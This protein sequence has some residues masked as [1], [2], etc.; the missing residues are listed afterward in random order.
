MC[1]EYKI[2]RKV[3]EGF[4]ESKDKFSY[5]DVSNEVL[6][7]GGVLAVA[8]G[9]TIREYL[10]YFVKKDFLRHD[11]WRDVYEKNYKII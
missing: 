10:D 4:V 9:T 11:Y 7:K 1:K 6:K 5:E 2:A 8:T 3:I